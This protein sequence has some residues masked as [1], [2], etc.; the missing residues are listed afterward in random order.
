MYTEQTQEELDRIEKMLS[1]LLERT[2]KAK[3]LD[4]PC[5]AILW[6]RINLARDV[7]RSVDVAV[8]ESMN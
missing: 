2:E 4:E 7:I 5:S 1:A 3:A 8:W 6:E